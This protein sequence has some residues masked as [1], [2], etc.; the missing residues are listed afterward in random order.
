MWGLGLK[1]GPSFYL[2]AETEMMYLLLNQL[3]IKK[4]NPLRD[5]SQ[6]FALYMSPGVNKQMQSGISM[7]TTFLYICLAKKR[8]ELDFV[9]LGSPEK[10]IS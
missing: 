5:W 6:L 2:Q 7:L 9:L 8:A 10:A 4:S 3:W 1:D